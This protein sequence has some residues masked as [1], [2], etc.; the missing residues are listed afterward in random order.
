MDNLWT[1]GAKKQAK[2]KSTEKLDDLLG[3][4]LVD[5]APSKKK[6]SSQPIGGV[7]P[8]TKKQGQTSPPP[9]SKDED[10]YSNLAATAEDDLS[11]ISEADVNQIA[12]SL[13]DLEDMDADLFGGKFKKKGSVKGGSERSSK[14]NTPRR[15]GTPRSR[16]TTPRAS[17]PQTRVTSPTARVTSP[18]GRVNSPAGRGT[19]SPT[20]ETSLTPRGGSLKKTSAKS[21][22]GASSIPEYKPG[23]APG[24]MTDIGSASESLKPGAAPIQERPGTV[25][26]TKSKYNYSD[27]DMDDLL[28]GFS[29]EDEDSIMGGKVKKTAPKQQKEDTTVKKQRSTEDTPQKPTEPDESKRRNLFDRPP[30]RSGGNTETEELPKTA[31]APQIKRKEEPGIFSDDDDFLGGLGIEEKESPVQKTKS[32]DE[33][34]RPARSVMDK[35]LAKDSAVSKHLETKKERREFVLDK[36]YTQP[37]NDE[38]EEDFQFGGYQ[39]SLVSTSSRPT[40]RRSVRFQDEDDIFGFDRPPSRGRSPASSLSKKPD[41]MDWLNDIATAVKSAPSISSTPPKQD[42]KPTHPQTD[43]KPTSAKTDSKPQTDTK[44]TESRPPDMDQEQKPDNLAPKPK[45]GAADWLGL[46]DADDEDEEPVVSWMTAKSK[47]KTT[48]PNSAGEKRKEWLTSHK[49]EETKP[50]T[51]QKTI[52][53]TDPKGSPADWLGLSS[54]KEEDDIDLG[55]GKDLD[56][57]SLLKT[58]LESP[59]FGGKSLRPNDRDLFKAPPKNAGPPSMPQQIFKP[60][61]SDTVEKTVMSQRSHGGGGMDELMGLPLTGGQTDRFDPP[62]EERRTAPTADQFNFSTTDHRQVMMAAHA[63][64]LK[65]QQQQQ[66]NLLAQQAQLEEM[67]KKQYEQTVKVPP[68]PVF[69]PE[70]RTSVMANP[71]RSL[72]DAQ[73]RL[74]K[75]E[76]ER[77]YAYSI[78]EMNKRRFEDERQTIESSYKSRL[79]LIEETHKNKETRLREENELLMNQYL[80]KVRQLENDKSEQ[81]SQYQRRLEDFQRDKDQDLDRLKSIHRRA[82]EDQKRE[83]EEDLE[84]LKKAKDQQIEAAITSHETTKSLVQAVSMI[85]NNAKDLGELHQKVDSWHNM[86]LDEREIAIRSKDEQLRILQERLNRQQE[87]NDMERKRL[88]DLIGRLETQLREQTRMLDEERWKVKQEQT[89]L[90]SMQTSLEEDRRLWTEQQ[91]RERSN[92]EKTRE[93]LLEEQKSVLSQLHKERQSVAEERTKLNVALTVHRDEAEDAAV[94]LAQAKAEFEALMKAISNEKNKQNVRRQEHQREEDQLDNER[95]KLEMEQSKMLEKEEYLVQTAQTLKEKSE[96]VDQLFVECQSKKEEG[97]NALLEAKRIEREES[98][99]SANLQHQVQ[100]LRL[101][102]REIADDRLR[103]SKEKKEVENLKSAMLC[104]NCRTPGG[105]G[106]KPQV[107]EQ[108]MAPQYSSAPTY[109][110]YSSPAMQPSNPAMQQSLNSVGSITET[111]KADRSMRMWKME[112]L[113]DQKYLEEQSMFL[114]TLKH[115]PYSGSK[116]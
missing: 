69:L 82:V 20:P 92:I 16:S 44:P 14:P 22:M 111:I 53:K 55:M 47:Q 91:A 58:R 28:A 110:V 43:T 45:S 1:P 18:V 67:M 23:T 26:K 90:Q 112:A 5:D 76:I 9:G 56:P 96:E 57:N 80:S 66:E 34:D 84:R 27:M 74:Y 83:Y 75:M 72:I 6:T 36:K 54:S 101:K 7:R 31:P 87:E 30:T 105:A 89:R 99:R 39:P 52:P 32:V 10:F 71:P 15:T 37:D 51:E 48:P 98:E 88:E 38:E 59:A 49:S 93:T 85:Q 94:K 13:A 103:L 115:M 19:N 12:K 46:N 41:D 42:S 107:G 73:T 8:G 97:N 40:S 102:E 78:L 29:D 4:L 114:Y 113:K 61:T 62:A 116:S 3:D 106:V 35:L 63:D 70:A 68:T 33:E 17:S 24:K 2:V 100:I 95:R 77:D 86:G 109:Q 64:V 79:E 104:P 11:D 60:P 81:S 21:A 50:K 108:I 65:Q 25:P